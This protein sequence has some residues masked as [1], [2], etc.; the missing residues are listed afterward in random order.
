MTTL[1]EPS[2]WA[3]LTKKRVLLCDKD[4]PKIGGYA[5][6]TFIEGVSEKQALTLN[7][8]DTVIADAGFIWLQV[9][10][11]A[12]NYVFTTVFAEQG[13][14]LLWKFELAKSCGIDKQRRLFYDSLPLSVVIRPREGVFMLGEDEYAAAV[15]SGEISE[16][17]ASA[18]SHILEEINEKAGDLKALTAASIDGFSYLLRNY[19]IDTGGKTGLLGHILPVLSKKNKRLPR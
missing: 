1:L 14:I 10:P 8:V 3:W 15:R 11:S 13:G 17:V 19:N 2:D 9:M 18:A 12:G 5:V 16:S 6:M 4:D 7:G